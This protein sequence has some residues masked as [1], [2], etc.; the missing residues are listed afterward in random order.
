MHRPIHCQPGSKGYAI[1]LDNTT[2]GA[3]AGVD[4][5]QQQLLDVVLP[6]HFGLPL[7]AADRAAMQEAL[8]QQAAA[9]ATT[10]SP[11]QT[12]AAPAA[13][14]EAPAARLVV[15]PPSE[16]RVGS[17]PYTVPISLSGAAQFS[18]VTMTISYNPA[19]LRVR[20]VSEGTFMRQGNV[21][22]TFTQQVDAAAGRIDIAIVRAGDA[23]G[24]T[25]SGLVAAVL[26]E[27][28]TAGTSTL[29]ITGS[30]TRVGGGSAVLTGSP[31][32]VVIR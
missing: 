11:P 21:T 2:A 14:S 31:A 8:A 16:M 13:L 24:V 4:P 12:A 22:P 23:I 17:G 26:F 19:L 25:A 20:S 1:A 6:G 7:P 30:A 10:S 29:T 3:Q 32:G 18:G 15:T 28:V 9:A 27:P 5:A